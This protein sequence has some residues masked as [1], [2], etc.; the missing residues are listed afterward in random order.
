MPIDVNFD[1][2]GLSADVDCHVLK[3]LFIQLFGTHGEALQMR[4]IAD[5]ILS[6]A[7]TGVGSTNETDGEESDPSAFL[8]V[9]SRDGHEVWFS[10]SDDF[11]PVGS[12]GSENGKNRSFKNTSSGQHR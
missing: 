10:H 8:M 3:W 7:D 12:T 5:L 11:P 2:F 9:S 6:V 1:G 4:K